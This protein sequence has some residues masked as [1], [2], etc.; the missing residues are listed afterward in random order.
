MD[1][2]TGMEPLANRRIVGSFSLALD[3]GGGKGV[4]VAGSN[5]DGRTPVWLTGASVA[6]GVGLRPSTLVLSTLMLSDSVGESVGALSSCL[7][8][9]L[10]S[11]WSQTVA[12]KPNSEAA[13][14]C[15]FVS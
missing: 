7:D 15:S 4:A 1:L 10:L 14:S 13:S 3:D 11:K 12:V 2:V 8:A 9:E 5:M 6:A